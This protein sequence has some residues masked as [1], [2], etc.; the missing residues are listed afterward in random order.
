MGL[1]TSSFFTGELSLSPTRGVRPDA[2]VGE[3]VEGK[4]SGPSSMPIL[5]LS[6]SQ[7]Q[8]QMA[9]TR[10]SLTSSGGDGGGEMGGGWG[11]RM[12][13]ACPASLKRSRVHTIGT[14]RAAGE[15]GRGV[16]HG[17]R[18]GWK[19]GRM[20]SLHQK[21][22]QGGEW[23]GLRGENMGGPGTAAAPPKIRG[24]PPSAHKAAG[25]VSV[26]RHPAPGRLLGGLLG[27]GRAGAV[28][29]PV[30]RVHRPGHQAGRRLAR[31]VRKKRR[32]LPGRRPAGRARRERGW[33]W[34]SHRPCPRH[35]R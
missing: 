33:W 11:E 10:C 5:S 32:R 16:A 34:W 27:R 17:G 4:G 31:K 6:L 14:A 1:F 13:G 29:D 26:G 24:F 7:Q 12:G 19:N 30:D 22:I 8:L 25:P 20:G 9:T 3:G 2:R 18:G 15:D 28:A 21:I 35:Q 23:V